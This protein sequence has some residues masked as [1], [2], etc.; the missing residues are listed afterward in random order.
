M[1]ASLLKRAKSQRHKIFYFTLGATTNTPKLLY[2]QLPDIIRHSELPTLIVHVAPAINKSLHVTDDMV[3]NVSFESRGDTRKQFI[4]KNKRLKVH[5][6]SRFVKQTHV[7]LLSSVVHWRSQRGLISVIGDF[8]ITGPYV[9]FSQDLTSSL[10]EVML[11]PYVYTIP[12]A[13][14]D[15][16]IVS[17]A[18]MQVN[19]ARAAALR[20]MAAVHIPTYTAPKSY[21]LRYYLGTKPHKSHHRQFI[22]ITGSARSGYVSINKRRNNPPISLS[23]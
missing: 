10:Q 12:N 11:L 4:S 2:Q 20:A 9:P 18:I 17:L 15:M 8:L 21:S 3:G 5:Y 16:G 14:S 7:N 22:N 13:T 6:V 1:L 23:P 19:A